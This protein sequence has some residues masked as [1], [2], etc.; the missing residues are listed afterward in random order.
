MALTCP[1]GHVN[2]EGNRFCEQCGAPLQQPQAD[3]AQPV[4][5]AVTSAGAT[6]STCPVCGQENVPGTAF[7]DNC[8]AALP[9]PMPAS[10]EP[11]P[12]APAEATPTSAPSTTAGGSTVACPNCGTENDAANRFCDNCGARLGGDAAAQ[13][14]AAQSGD[15]I[16][17]AQPEAAADQ[18]SSS[19]QIID[20]PGLNDD[21]SAAPAADTTPPAPDATA[22]PPASAEEAAP[23]AIDPTL[24]APEAP[25]AAATTDTSADRQ[26]L[27]EEIRTQ[28]QV[29]SQLEQM[30]TSLGA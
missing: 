6:S 10:E 3:V 7:C 27:E 20:T 26:R 11:A 5:Q 14:D 15:A 22:T 9:P 2:D 19:A 12:S 18:A 29:V 17:A 28:Q 4:A 16:A 21:Q 1:N 25:P 13:P 30:Q 24:T 23:A 8:G